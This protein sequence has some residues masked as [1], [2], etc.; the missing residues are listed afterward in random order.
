MSFPALIPSSRAFS[1]GSL[2]VRNYRTLSGAIWK[3]AF[4]NTRA[5]HSLTLEFT[6]IPD[7]QADQIVAHYEAMG[8]P[9][10]RFTLPGSIFAGM[11]ATMAARIQ[12][13]TNV[14][15]A[16]SSEPKVASVFPGV[17]TVSV[18]LVGEVAYP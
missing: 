6:N 11:D 10:Y 13:P 3:R 5:G 8:G 15:W 2:P 17:S 4:S 7:S 16:Y 12:A 1:P 9:F 14:Q 18:D